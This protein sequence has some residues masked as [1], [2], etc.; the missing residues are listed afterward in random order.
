MYCLYG[1]VETGHSMLT[2]V[3]TIVVQECSSE[4]KLTMTPLRG[5]FGL[6][7]CPPKFI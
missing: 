7:F 4:T 5:Q 6:G 2:S 3:I 1:K